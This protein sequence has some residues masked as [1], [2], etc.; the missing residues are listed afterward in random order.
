MVKRK[1]QGFAKLHPVRL[2]IAA[3]IISA[4]CA[5]LITLFASYFPI[6]ATFL[7]SIY[8]NFGYSLS[9]IGAILGMIYIFID[10]FILIWLFAIIYNKLLS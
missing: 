1:N 10:T 8:S 6:C 4:I 9:F 2:G 5:V 3:G 7:L